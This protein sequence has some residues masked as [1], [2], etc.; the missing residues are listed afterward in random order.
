[1]ELENNEVVINRA[2]LV[3]LNHTRRKSEISIE[4]SMEELEELAKAAGVEVLATTTQ[5]RPAIDV[6]LFVGKGKVEEIKTFCDSMEANLVIFDDELSGSQI[7]NLEDA[8]GVDV[9]DRTTLILDIFAQRAT[10]KEA[11][12]QVELAQLKYR[13]P[14]LTGLGKKLSRLGAGIGTRG[15]GETKLE[16]DRRHILRKIDFIKEQLEEVKK[17]REVQRSQRI[18][19]DLP[20]VALVGYTNAGKSTLMN[21]LLKMSLEYDVEREV[22]VKDMLFATLEV[23]LRKLVFP[24]NFTFLLTDT[25]GFVSKLPHNLV[26]A[27]K[28]TLEEVN[29]ADLLLHVIDASNEDYHLQKETTLSVLKELHVDSK[30]IINVYNKVDKIEDVSLV[31]KEEGS[32]AISA[33]N[34]LNLDELLKLI[35]VEVGVKTNELELLIP[36]S[37]GSVASNI[38][39][40]AS[41]VESEYKE[42]GI[43]LKVKIP[44][45]EVEKYR[46]FIM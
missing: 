36:Y 45:T 39:E 44:S 33:L 2:I 25:V 46:E 27:F 30:K 35:E 40:I 10:T 18:K 43:Y 29:Y 21:T 1:M 23:S 5:N 13:L 22:F 9:I 4:S 12:L 14:R 32:I 37:K 34:N 38:H 20:I 15:P 31:P 19:S 42:E 7:R 41:V 24:D 17:V 26:D 6:A 8:I 16:T 3:G 11:K 28:A